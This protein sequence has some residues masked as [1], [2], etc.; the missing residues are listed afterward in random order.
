MGEIASFSFSFVQP[1]EK[2]FMESTK[3]LLFL[4]ISKVTSKQSFTDPSSCRHYGI[5]HL[6]SSQQKHWGPSV[7]QLPPSNFLNTN[8]YVYINVW[9]SIAWLK[10]TL[11]A[12]S[13]HILHKYYNNAFRIVHH[14]FIFYSVWLVLQWCVKQ[15][16]I[17]LHLTTKL[18]TKAPY[19]ACEIYCL[20]FMNEQN[21]NFT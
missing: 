10:F 11:H 6:K 15:I 12:V 20:F 14:L 16:S 18:T 17:L 9:M 7:I 5:I 13:P 3:M 21:C 1:A 2:V 4:T 8:I 19:A